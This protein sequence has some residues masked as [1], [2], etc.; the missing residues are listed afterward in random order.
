VVLRRSRE[1]GTAADV[2]GPDGKHEL[3]LND[4][5]KALSFE[6]DSSGF[7]E[8]QRANGR[9]SL[10]AVHADRRESDLTSIPE[11]TLV[12]W[13]NTGSSAAVADQPASQQQTIPWSLWRYALLLVL[14]AALVESLFASRYLKEERQTA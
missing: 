1:Q 6:L 3:T 11:E 10:V 2:T 13:R 7:Y 12:L 4:A 14:I 5:T 8:V 9:R